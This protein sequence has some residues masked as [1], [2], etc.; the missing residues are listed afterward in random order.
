MTSNIFYFQSYF[1]TGVGNKC[2][3]F[4]CISSTDI[5]KCWRRLL[6]L[7][8]CNIMINTCIVWSYYSHLTPPVLHAYFQTEVGNKCTGSDC[9]SFTDNFTFWRRLLAYCLVVFIL[10]NTSSIKCFKYFS[11]CRLS[12]RGIEIVISSNNHLTI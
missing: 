11:L 4:G 6:A 3:G 9:F 5:F 1:Q 2:T 10:I 12:R 8:V 7:V